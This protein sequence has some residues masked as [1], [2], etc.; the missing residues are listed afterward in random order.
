MEDVHKQ[1]LRRALILVL[2]NAVE[3][4]VDLMYVVK[5]SARGEKERL[6]QDSGSESVDFVKLACEVLLVM[7]KACHY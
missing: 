2:H 3:S 1:D 5:S 6:S 4:A 7:D